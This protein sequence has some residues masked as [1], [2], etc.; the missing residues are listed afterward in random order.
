M[1]D[2]ARPVVDLSA[3]CACGAVSLVVKGTVYSMFLCSCEDCQKASGTGHSAVFMV[4]PSALTVTGE[5]RGYDVVA[6]SGA[7]FTRYFCPVCGTRLHCRSSRTERSVMLP[8]GLFGEDT[9]WF[10]PNQLIFSR[11]HRDWDTIAV[12]LPRYETYRQRSEEH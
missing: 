9:D 1:R 7:T 3:T 12:D 6:D 11:T 10:V 4:D 5:T 2:R 8:A